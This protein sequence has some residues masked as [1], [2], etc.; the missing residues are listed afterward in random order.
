[1]GV[2]VE[3]GVGVDTHDNKVITE[4]FLFCCLAYLPGSIFYRIL[5]MVFANERGRR[6]YI[7]PSLV[8]WD[9]G[10]KWIKN[11]PWNT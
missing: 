3:V 8:D 10:D 11:G 1:M 4:M 6:M 9:H 5:R 7:T 2:G